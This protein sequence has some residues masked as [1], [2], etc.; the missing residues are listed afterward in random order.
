MPN[1]LGRKERFFAPGLSKNL[2]ICGIT[3]DLMNSIAIKDKTIQER[4]KSFPNWEERYH[5]II[6]TG[7][8]MPGLSDAEKS[9]DLKVKGCQSQVWIKA[10][11]SPDGR[12]IFRA[13]SDALVVRGLIALLVEIYSGEKPDEIISYSPQFIES[14]ELANHLSPSRAN[15]LFSMLKQIKYYGLAFKALQAQR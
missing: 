5:H 13:D 15:G 2:A 11:L 10:E 7:R 14:L 12:V 1:R 8:E 9:E 3:L 4:F 6:K